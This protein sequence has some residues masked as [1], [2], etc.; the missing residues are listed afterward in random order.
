M[1]SEMS[2]EIGLNSSAL[3]LNLWNIH[4]VCTLIVNFIINLA[5]ILL[6]TLLPLFTLTIGC[7][8][9]MV[10]L[11]TLILTASSLLFRPLF[12]NLIDTKG[13]RVVLII[14]LCIFAT[15]TIFL[16]FSPNIVLLLLLR[17]FQ[18]IGLSGYSTALGTILSDIVPS[19]KLSEGVGYFG[20][21]ATIAMAVA[22][23]LGL[24]FNDKFGYPAAFAAAFGFVLLSLGVAFFISYESRASILPKKHSRNSISVTSVGKEKDKS[25]I[26]ISAIKTCVVVV[27]TSFAVSSVFSFMPLFAKE[28]GINNIGLFF[29]VYAASVIVTRFLTGRAADQY[30]YSKVFV[31]A[32]IITLLLFITLIF[33]H[34]LPMVLLAAVFYGV[35]YGTVQPILNAIVIKLSPP[36]RRGAATATYYAT[37]DIGFGIGSFVWGAISQAAGFGA[38]FL[39]CALS[40]ALALSA[41]W[42]ILHPSLKESV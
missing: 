4:Y 33:A 34:T 12:G 19:E 20:I 38:V 37:L 41:Y 35:G 16:I 8:N 9:T 3:Q 27:F 24:H 2:E 28:R 11:L 30:G 7:N 14:G 23:A 32:I 15:A 25:F 42:Y 31:P 17:F 29:A 39:G 1:N 6:M 10:G 5:S 26:E 13:R 18:G 22:P 40:I 21:S 36:E